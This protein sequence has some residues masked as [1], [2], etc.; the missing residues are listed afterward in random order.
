MVYVEHDPLA[1]F[2]KGE[3]KNTLV[4]SGSRK[5]TLVES[6]SGREW[7]SFT[8]ALPTDAFPRG[9]GC[10]HFVDSRSPKTIDPHISTTPG[11]ATRRVFAD[12]R[13]RHRV[14]QAQRAA[15]PSNGESQKR[16]R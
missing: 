10:T 9:E 12:Q 11:D 16:V 8:A 15:R 7:R 3:T 6:G 14:R 1:T 4:E 13:G 5:N 2:K